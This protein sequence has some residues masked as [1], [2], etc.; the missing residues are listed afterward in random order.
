V[1]DGHRKVRA[2][3]GLELPILAMASTRTVSARRWSP[4]IQH[5]DAVLDA[6]R[7]AHLSASLGRHVSVTRI[8]EGMHNLVLSLPP[9]REATYAAIGS[10]LDALPG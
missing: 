6:G 3:V 2:G 7:I 10:W 8:P 4:D 5:G 9:A 1:A